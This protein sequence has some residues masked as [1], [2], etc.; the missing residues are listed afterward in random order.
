MTAARHQASGARRVRPIQTTALV[1]TTT[2]QTMGSTR[3]E[4][5][6]G[7]RAARGE[8]PSARRLASPALSSLPPPARHRAVSYTHLRAHETLMNL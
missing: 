1:R 7:A 3:M 4:R 6:T 8:G 5:V 2:A